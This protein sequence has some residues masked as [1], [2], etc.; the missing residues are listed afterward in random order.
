MISSIVC[1]SII[2]S[3][4]VL[5]DCMIITMIVDKHDDNTN[6][7]TDNYNYNNND[8]HS[9]IISSSIICIAAQEWNACSASCEGGTKFR[10]RVAKTTANEYI[11][12]YIYVYIY[13]YI[14]DINRLSCINRLLGYQVDNEQVIT[15]E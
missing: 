1:T 6:D 4:S 14:Q 15:Y 8:N 10:N 7:N 13:I 9:I 12:I 2:I 3:N 5:N 11:Y